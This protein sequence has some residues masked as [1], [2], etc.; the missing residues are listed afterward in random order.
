MIYHKNAAAVQ[1]TKSYM[2]HILSWNNFIIYKLSD[3]YN[4]VFPLSK[5]I[6]HHIG[7]LFSVE[8]PQ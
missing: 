8:N 5:I 1:F 7:T 6:H 4:Y 2:N 3:V